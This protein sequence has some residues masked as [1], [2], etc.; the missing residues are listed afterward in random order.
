MVA[1]AARRVPAGRAGST[2]PTRLP[3]PAG[4]G[5]RDIAD[6][7]TLIG[8]VYDNGVG[9]A[10]Y[11]WD[12][13]GN[14][15]KLE[16]PA[17]RTTGATAAAGDWIAGGQWPDMIPVLWNRRTGKLV[18]VGATAKPGKEGPGPAEAVNASG[19]VVTRGSVYR[20]GRQLTLEAPRGQTARATTVADDGLILG[21]TLDESG[22]SLGPKAWRC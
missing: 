10:A 4:A 18:K 9:V 6:D 13:Q 2:T 14:G 8:T 7:G 21:L 22:E 20:G 3:L 1:G 5:V 19:L 12:Q 11:T 17:G 15:R 16:T